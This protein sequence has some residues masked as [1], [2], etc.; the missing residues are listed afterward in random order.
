MG[1]RIKE[2]TRRFVGSMPLGWIRRY[3]GWKFG[4][5]D[6]S[7]SPDGE[8]LILKNLLQDT[9]NGFYVDIGAYHPVKFSNTFAL[10]E[11]GWH[12]LN[13]D[14]MPGSMK[15]FKTKRP[16][17]IN[18]ETAI[19]DDNEQV[20]Y[21]TFDE[22]AYNTFSSE[23]AERCERDGQRQTGEKKILTEKLSDVLAKYLPIN[24]RIDFMSIDVEGYDLKVLKSNDWVKYRPAFI[25]V[26]EKGFDAEKPN[27]SKIFGFLKERGYRLVIAT[28]KN[29]FFVDAD[30]RR[31]Q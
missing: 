31:T 30:N 6:I 13:I 3:L 17:D 15:Q 2:Q 22:Q 25:M 4:Y 29:I 9:K 27:E 28:P 12:G 21:Y 5:A 20:T 24:Q 7:F 1:P 14:A 19:S 10:Y 16:R 11:S 8:D 26:E 23:L 18:V